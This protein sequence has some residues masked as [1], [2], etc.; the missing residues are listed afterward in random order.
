[1]RSPLTLLLSGLRLAAAPLLLAS[2]VL[3]GCYN[4]DLGPNPYLCASS[5]KKCPDG[6]TCQTRG[7]VQVCV[8]DGL[9][10][11]AMPDRR[12]LTDAELVPSK[13]GPLYLDGAIVK[14]AKGCK[15]EQSEPNNS[16]DTATLIPSPGFI[17]NWEICY[18]GDVDQF[19]IPLELGDRLVVKVKFTHSLG[20]LD[21]G[22]VDPAGRVIDES[23]SLTNE[24]IVTVATADKK[25]KYVV[26]VFGFGTA[27][28]TY[29]LDVT[30][31]H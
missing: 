8:K 21:V 28:N 16:A 24:E 30:I 10:D 6:Y 31:S 15:D 2:A 26:G 20:D 23:R 22:L 14:P 13:E 17:P 12:I 4:P 18:P 1:M 7:N 11:A 27:T 19:A 9:P 29:D 3:T 5:G 25:G